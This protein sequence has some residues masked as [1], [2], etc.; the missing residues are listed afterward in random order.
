MTKTI[1]LIFALLIITIAFAEETNPPVSNDQLVKDI[2]RLS[3]HIYEEVGTHSSDN[4]SLMKVHQLLIQSIAILRGEQPTNPQKPY[5]RYE[6]IKYMLDKGHMPSSARTTCDSIKTM[7]EYS[8][9]K[10]VIDAG[11]YPSSSVKNCSG[12]IPE[13]L[14]CFADLLKRGYGPERARDTCISGQL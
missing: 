7:A 5:D 6:C 14:D 2:K 4:E 13:E 9:V 8:C 3:D 1:T 12:I 11:F 10:M